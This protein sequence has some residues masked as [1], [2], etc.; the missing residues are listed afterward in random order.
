MKK[1]TRIDNFTL[2]FG[3]VAKNH[4]DGLLQNLIFLIHSITIFKDV[5]PNCEHIFVY[6]YVYLYD[7]HLMFEL[8][9]FGEVPRNKNRTSDKSILNISLNSR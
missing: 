9:V 5:F 3:A 8:K 4:R 2:N 1:K 7:L 6:R